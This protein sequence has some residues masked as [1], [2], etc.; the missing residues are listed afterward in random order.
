ML[1]EADNGDGNEDDSGY[2]GAAAS[3]RDE[4]VRRRN[5]REDPHTH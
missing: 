2:S 5:A 3:L 4:D 1:I